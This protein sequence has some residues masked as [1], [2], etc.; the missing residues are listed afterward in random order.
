MRTF[1]HCILMVQIHVLCI[2]NRHPRY[3]PEFPSLTLSPVRG[4]LRMASCGSVTEYGSSSLVRHL[5]V[6]FLLKSIFFIS[7]LHPSCFSSDQRNFFFTEFQNSTFCI[8]SHFQT[9]SIP[10]Q[11]DRPVTSHRKCTVQVCKILHLWL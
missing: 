11:P 7:N 6:Q 4:S 3:H 1:F 10:G 8:C 9:F 2:H 5:Q